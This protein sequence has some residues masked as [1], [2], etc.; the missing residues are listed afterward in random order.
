M[1]V[2]GKE[3]HS[4]AV[5]AQDIKGKKL[6]LDNEDLQPLKLAD[7]TWTHLTYTMFWFSAV[8]TVTNW[9]A[10]S[11]AQAL[12]LSMWESLGCAFGGQVLIAIIMAL[13]GRAGATY[14]IGFPVVCRTAFGVYGAWWP[15]FNRAVSAVVWN[16]VNLVQGGQCVYVMLHALTPSIAAIP[17][18]MGSGSSLTSGGMIGFAVFWLVTCFFLVIPV[19]KMRILI[20][21]KLGVFVV[22]AIAMVAW[23]ATKAGGLG[24]VISQPGTATGETRTWLIV[25][26]FLLGASNSA[27]FASN[28]ADFQRYAQRKNDVLLGNVFGFPVSNLI[29]AIAG[30]LVCASSQLIFGKLVWNPITLLDMLQSTEYTA[31]NRA[32]CFFLAAMFAYSCIFSTIFENSLPAGNDIAALFPKY[33]TVRR[34]FFICAVLSFAICPWYLLGSAIVFVSFLSSYQV[35]LATITGILLANYYLISKGKISI[36]DAFTPSKDGAYYFTH[37]WNIRAYIA[38]IVGIAPNFYGF[39][40]NMGVAAPVSI[41]RFYYFAYWV[42]LFLS[43]GVFWALCQFFPV[44][45]QEERWCEPKDYVRPEERE[46]NMPAAVIDASEVGSSDGSATKVAVPETT[47]EKVLV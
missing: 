39:L 24:A 9:Y 17:N 33:V 21:I 32:G 18:T 41:S 15:T 47:T 19:P 38:Y 4:V 6:T 26:F 46:E 42:G 3:F 7:R 12:G 5:G 8:A 22:S 1:R 25:R 43:G 36:P 28:A 27:T 34:G 31:A 11:A 10:A 29:V 40:N 13:N 16:G 35:F 23:T 37:G 2:F 30:N 20:Y 14:H 44:P 45:I